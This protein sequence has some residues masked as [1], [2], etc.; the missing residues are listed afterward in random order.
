MLQSRQTIPL[1]A[2]YRRH[3]ASS[4]LAL[5][6][7]R[8]ISSCG[9]GVFFTIC[10]RMSFSPIAHS[11]HAAQLLPVPSKLFAYALVILLL[12]NLYHAFIPVVKCFG[13]QFN[14]FR[15]YPKHYIATDRD[16]DD[17]IYC[18]YGT[19]DPNSGDNQWSCSKNNRVNCYFWA[20]EW[21]NGGYSEH[22]VINIPSG[23]YGGYATFEI[24]FDPGVKDNCNSNQKQG[25]WS[26]QIYGPTNDNWPNGHSICNP[27][28]AENPKDYITIGEELHNSGAESPSSLLIDNSWMDG[29]F[30]W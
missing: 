3:P 7:T 30:H 16:E 8:A 4:I 19:Y 14:N 24:H 9:F 21:Y 15:I 13:M 2:C 12:G 5:N 17:M 26:I 11:L 29:Q 10:H 6:I 18:G 27:M 25:H 28:A 22:A 23:D 1:H 20:D